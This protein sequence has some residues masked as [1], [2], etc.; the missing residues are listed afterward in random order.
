MGNSNPNCALNS[1]DDSIVAVHGLNPGSKSNHGRRTWAVGE[2]DDERLWLRDFL[3]SKVPEARILL[4]G[5]DSS[6]INGSKMHLTDHA[7]NLLN[8]LESKRTAAPERPILFIAH[9]LG[10]LVVKQAMVEA[11]KTENPICVATYGMMFFATPHRG[12]NMATFGT[13]TLR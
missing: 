1:H 8:R 4:F 7:K 5:Y 10:G 12:G 3:P 13:S 2:G 6:V 9:S 11:R